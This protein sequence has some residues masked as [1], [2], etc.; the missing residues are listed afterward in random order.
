MSAYCKMVV[1]QLDYELARLRQAARRHRRFLI[2]VE[3]RGGQPSFR[4]GDRIGIAQVPDIV[5]G[6]VG[7][8]ERCRASPASA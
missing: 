8:R 4:R 3:R 1:G 5:L 6:I 2:D 7:R